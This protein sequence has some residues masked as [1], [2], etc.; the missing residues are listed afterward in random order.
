MDEIIY[1]N[2]TVYAKLGPSPI[3]GVGV[4]AIRDIPKGT[5]ITDHSIQNISGTKRLLRIPVV[6]FDK[7]LPE[8]RALVLDRMLFLDG[9]RIF[10]F[11]S[12][13]LDAALQSFMNHSTIPN[14]NG[15]VALRDILKG[16]EITEDFKSISG[17][18]HA[19]TKAHHT[20]L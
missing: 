2:T 18:L 7:I 4:F 15:V 1:L 11:Y 3:H 12:P 17:P 13:N 6:D 5:R 20:F 8:I 10:T 16:E 9:L 14:S 19:L